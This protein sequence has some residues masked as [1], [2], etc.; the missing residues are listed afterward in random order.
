MNNIMYKIKRYFR[1]IAV[2]NLMTYVAASMAIIF[3]GDL[4]TQG[5][6]LPLLMFNRAAI[7]EGQA[8]RLITF[9][10]VPQTTEVFWIVLSVYFYWFLGRDIEDSWGSH[11]LTMYF[12]LGAAMLIG[13]GF[14]TGFASSE[15]LYFSM[16]LVYAYLHPNMEIRL[17]MIIPLA[18]KWIA[19]IDIVFMLYGFAESFEYYF[20]GA[21]SYAA[22]IQLSII[23]SFVCFAVFFGKTY[24][25]RFKNKRRHKDFISVMKRKNIEVTRHNED[26]DDE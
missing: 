26:D 15:Y 25:E 10:L 20:M 19:L 13:I 11:N 16:F 1:N 12:L 18:A 24:I 21:V 6:L 7:L 3:V 5:R 23:A 14:L 8:W 22:G 17:F 2:E 4:F 9:L